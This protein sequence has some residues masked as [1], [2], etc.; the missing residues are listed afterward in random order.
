[1]FVSTFIVD[2]IIVTVDTISGDNMKYCSI[3]TDEYDN[4][5]CD[6]LDK[7]LEV[8]VLIIGGGITGMSVAYHLRNS[9]LKVCLVEKNQ[10][11]SGVTSRTTGK[12]T[13][14][15][16]CIYSK[17][18][19]THSKK[20]AHLYLE[21]QKDAISMVKAIIDENKI[22]CD[23]QKVS[24]YVYAD[25]ISEI[26][27]VQKEMNLLLEFGVDVKSVS[28]LPNGVSCF[29]GI[30]IDDSA[31]FHPLKYL[32]GLFKAIGNQVLFYDHT[33]VTSIQKKD[34]RYV[35]MANGCEI[36]V[37]KV[38]LALHYPYFI[39][40]YL[41]P[42]RV[43][44]E[45]SY[46]CAYPVNFNFSFSA[47]TSSFPTTSLRYHDTGDRCYEIYLKGSRNLSVKNDE[48][49]QFLKLY[50]ELLRKPDYMW[51]NIDV[52][53]DD[54][55][56]YMG[57]LK[58]GMY[59]ATGYQTW[60]MTNGSLAGKVIGDL[61]L[62][63][64]NRYSSLFALYRKFTFSRLFHLP[65]SIGSSL[66]AYVST[67]LFPNKKWYHNQVY[68]SKIDGKSV[69]VY[70][71]DQG[72]RHMVF[73]RCPHMRCGLIF[74]FLEKTWD[75]PCHGSRFDLDGCCIEGPSN[76]SISV[77]EEVCYNEKKIK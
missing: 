17:L 2:K 65:I 3:W 1:M 4:M 69:L 24:S 76:Y 40:P 25:K 18:S 16:E 60:G 58:E 49:K 61:I 73:N 67:W 64:Y 54:F 62:K 20:I 37:S 23:Y 71:D 33:T 7:N 70:V 48:E 43:H 31:V 12:L 42:F 26:D 29:D 36:L 46:L 30:Y 34:N 21:S 22:D 38:V 75:C 52:M 10:I 44:L 11:G 14:L 47:I 5:Q 39:F 8:D 74:N 27:Q 51:S 53:T 77:L 6:A 13:Y 32:K 15:Q 55:L 56:P 35:C 28:S 66:S 9:D 59:L 63:R 50:D 68:S 57:E 19:K 72:N 45:R 41:F